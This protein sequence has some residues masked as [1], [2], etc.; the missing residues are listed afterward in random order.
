MFMIIVPVLLV[1]FASVIGWRQSACSKIATAG[2]ACFYYRHIQRII[3]A[4]R[5][6]GT[7]VQMTADIDR[8]SL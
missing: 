4:A 1:P 6:D 7:E 3:H 2:S 5:I 8:V